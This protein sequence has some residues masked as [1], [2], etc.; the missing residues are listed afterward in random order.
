MRVKLKK[1]CLVY[2]L[3]KGYE[4]EVENQDD[5]FWSRCPFYQ[6]WAKGLDGHKR[7]VTYDQDECEVVDWS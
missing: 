5:G 2:N 4:F 1:E 6:G 3:P 7:L